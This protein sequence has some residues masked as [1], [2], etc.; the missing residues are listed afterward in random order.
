[1]HPTPLPI[2]KVI[3]NTGKLS[4]QIPAD[5]VWNGYRYTF[6]RA[7]TRY[8]YLIVYDDILGKNGRKFASES[9]PCPT[10]NVI[11]VTHEPSAVKTHGTDF[12]RQF[13]HVLTCHEEWSL[14]H[15]GR[16]TMQPMSPWWYRLNHSAPYEELH[17]MPPPPKPKLLSTICSPKQ[18]THT[19]HRHRYA[20]TQRIS[21]LVP[22]LEWWGRGKKAIDDKSVAMDD[23]RYHLA[24]ENHICPHYWTE[25]LADSYLAYCLPFYYGCPNITEYFPPQSLIILDI[26][27]AEKSARIIADA[28]Q[29][30]EYEKRLPAIQE[31]RRRL[32]EEHNFFPTMSRFIANL[33]PPQSKSATRAVIYSR[34]AVISRSPLS[35]LRYVTEKW[36]NR[37]RFQRQYQKSP[38]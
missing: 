38:L 31:A 33:P 36:R 13:S 22:Q 14:Q 6:D 18:H 15:K 12:C 19:L 10:E 21:E 26:N 1:M 20:F 2:V 29:N 9:L 30:A 11:F 3:T 25:K 37:L 34:R 8:D 7:A 16:V 35:G 27:D 23:Y 4:R 24:I 28:I 5:G 17:R 32:L